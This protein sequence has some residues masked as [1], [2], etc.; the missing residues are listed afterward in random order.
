MQRSK[1]RSR[2]KPQLP[3]FTSQLTVGLS[4]PLRN[5]VGEMLYGIQA[6]QEIQLSSV[7]RSSR[8]GIPLIKTEDRLSRNL[9]AKELEAHLRTALLCLGGQRVQTHTV[10]MSGSQ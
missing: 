7:A 6:S 3:K 5:F 1:I 8:E 2:L 4:K 9:R 10:L